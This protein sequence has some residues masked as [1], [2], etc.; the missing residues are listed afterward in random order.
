MC[1]IRREACPR[2]EMTSDVETGKIEKRE[3]VQDHKFARSGSQ[4][5][6]QGEAD[7]ETCQCREVAS[8][9]D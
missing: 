9:E 6:E 1:G 5:G 3:H 4:Q 2:C 8:P 7:D